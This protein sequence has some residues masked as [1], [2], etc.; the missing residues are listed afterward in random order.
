M[1]ERGEPLFADQI[2]R[3]GVLRRAQYVAGAHGGRR[4]FG[5][6]GDHPRRAEIDDLHRAGLVDHDVLRPQILVQHFLA[7]KRAQAGGD[8]FDDAA[9]R[10]QV[11]PRIVDH[12]LGRVCPSMNSVTT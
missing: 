11:R 6:A 2:F 8:L 4:G 10:F 7:V 9:H 5:D 12:P 1:S 3:R